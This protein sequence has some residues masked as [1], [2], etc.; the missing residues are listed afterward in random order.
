MNQGSDDEDEMMGS[1][2]GQGDVDQ[3][4]MEAS[5]EGNTVDCFAQQ[6]GKGT[7]TK[8]LIK[9]G[10]EF[11]NPREGWAAAPATRGG[12]SDLHNRDNN[13][14]NN[15]EPRIP[16]PRMNAVPKTKRPPPKL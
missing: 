14:N 12:P 6:L 7:V 11:D 3:C 9:A 5:E 8:K 1:H 16:Q 4:H 15:A 2:V 10:V 13:N